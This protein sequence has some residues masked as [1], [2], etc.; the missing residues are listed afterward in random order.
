MKHYDCVVLYNA[1]SI[2][3]KEGSEE[4]IYPANI[5]REE[6]GA[7]EESLRNAGFHPYV[8][9]VEFF[10]RD[11]IQ[12]LL[13]I[14]PRFVFNLCEEVNGK[15]ELEMCIAGL[16]ELMGIPYTGSDPFALGLAL[17][18]FH[19]KQILRSAG[20]PTARG[21]LRF[22]GQKLTIPRGMRFPMIVKPSRQD[23][24]LG[25]NSHSVCQTAEQLERQI[26][27][28]HDV[29]EQ[30]ALVEE[31][32]DGK[33]FNVSVIGDQDPEVL[34]I[35]EIDFTDLPEGEPRIVSYRA[36]WDEES[37]L[38]DST[39]PICPAHLSKRLENR[40]K[41]I[42]VRSHLC[43]GC[44]DY[45]RVD[46]RTDTRGNLYVLEVNP[47]PDISPRAGFARAARAA[48]YSY[49]EMILRISEAALERGAKVAA[50]VYAF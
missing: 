17:N 20:I 13:E 2:M 36:K 50:A 47:N 42:A 21:Y 4:K 16:L 38:Y 49:P 30:E 27:Y 3:E 41:D 45:A 12:T 28:I 1:A 39:V 46:M 14:S 26:L 5:L 43:V 32:L 10:S 9:S 11:L 35:S 23:A 44:R 24:S 15:C 31:Y 33:E 48:G 40:I 34:A 29:Y 7:I 8:L 25:I 6:V 22:P 37:P 19:V 18:K